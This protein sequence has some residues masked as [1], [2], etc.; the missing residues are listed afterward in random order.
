MVCPPRSIVLSKVDHASW[1][2]FVFF[3]QLHLPPMSISSDE[4]NYLIYRY[5]IESGFSHSSFSFGY[6]TAIHHVELKHR[7]SPILSP[8]WAFSNRENYIFIFYRFRKAP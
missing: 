8:T 5:L 4:V 1:G 3:E 6:E 2:H 7:V